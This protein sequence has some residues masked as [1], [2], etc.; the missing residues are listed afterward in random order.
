MKMYRFFCFA[1]SLMMIT[2]NAE[3]LDSKVEPTQALI[4]DSTP[5]LQPQPSP[6][7]P[8]IPQT[9]PLEI[10]PQIESH[11][12]SY[13]SAFYKMLFVLLGIIV[14]VFLLFFLFRKLSNSRMNQSNQFRSIK[15]LEKRAI[16][17]KSMLYLVEIGGQKILLAESQLEIRNVSNLEWIDAPKQGL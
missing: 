9:E 15:I 5:S 16:S 8:S 17:P 13:E 10:E 12:S 2:L 6:T 4:T 7:K 3:E 11:T 14:L 1:V